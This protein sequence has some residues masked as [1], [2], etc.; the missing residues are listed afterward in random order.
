MGCICA[1]ESDIE[2]FLTD[3]I[4]ELKIRKYNEKNFFAYLD[5]NSPYRTL[6][7]NYD[8]FL[9]SNQNEEIHSIYQNNLFSRKH[10]LFYASLIFLIHSDPKNMSANYK[11][12]IEKIK[13]SHTEFKQDTL[14]DFTKDDYDILSDVLNFYV[15]MISLDV[16]EAAQKSKE[17]RITDEQ[18][19]VLK[20]NYAE[21]VI[22]IY[23]KDLM[24][25]CKNP[26]ID[27]DEFFKKNHLELVHTTVREKL[28]KVFENKEDIL[29]NVK[30]ETQGRKSNA[31]ANANANIK[32]EDANKNASENNKPAGNEQELEGGEKYQYKLPNIEYTG[33]NGLSKEHY[34]SNNYDKLKSE[35][36]HINDDY[37]DDCVQ[38]GNPGDFN[39]ENER[40]RLEMEK[41]KEEQYAIY[42]KECLFHHNK[43]REIHGVPPL[44]EDN[45]LSEYSQQWANFISETDT[46]THSSMIW[47]GKN[48]GENIAKAGAIINDPSQLI[49]NKWYEEKDNFDYSNPSSH[50]NTKNFTQMV[51]KNTESIGF[52]LAYSESGNTFIV[53]NYHPAGNSSDGYKDNVTL[54]RD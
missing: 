24:K 11:L 22:A 4:D 36:N 32:S 10:H 8:E 19:K 52:G 34:G 51:W 25:D 46:L 5:K 20:N 18:M 45:S 44:K 2:H 26:N 7:S 40:I 17:N 16:I 9:R 15:R 42:R 12:V 23:V 50:N 54:P 41:L 39:M 27:L 6:R 28:K 3:F 48:V 13:N 43:V 47:D 21:T 1:G 35:Q 49:V 14:Q 30:K 29:K 37:D 33:E 38:G 53:I 31:N